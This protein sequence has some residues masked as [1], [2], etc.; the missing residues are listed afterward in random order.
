MFHVEHFWFTRKK[1]LHKQKVCAI[2]LS[3][4]TKKTNKENHVGLRLDDASLT[5]LDG[6]C[7]AVGGASRSRVLRRLLEYLQPDP[8][9]RYTDD[10]GKPVEQNPRRRDFVEWFRRMDDAM[11]AT[12]TDGIA[13]AMRRR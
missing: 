11:I 2:L 1:V 9:D 13:D 6:L 3:M 10:A 7:D 8:S 4:K 5:I 12:I